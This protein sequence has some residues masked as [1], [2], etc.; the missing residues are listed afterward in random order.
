MIYIVELGYCG[1]PFQVHKCFKSESDARAY[2]DAIPDEDKEWDDYI[3]SRHE[4][5]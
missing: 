4:L 5:H 3:I 2:I 1:D